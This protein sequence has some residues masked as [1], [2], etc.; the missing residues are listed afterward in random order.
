MSLT[1]S[2][3]RPLTSPLTR[4]L[5]AAGGG[6]AQPSALSA[7]KAGIVADE[8]DIHILW[9]GDSTSNETT[10]LP[11]ISAEWLFEQYP[12]HTVSYRLFNDGGNS[13]DAA[14]VIGT[15]S[16]ANTIHIW[17]ASVSGSE[18]MYLMGDRFDAAIGDLTPDV[19]IWNH[20]HNMTTY[21]NTSG[22]R[23]AFLSGMEPVR[24]AHPGVPHVAIRQN[25][26]RDGDEMAPVVE[27][28]DGVAAS[29]GDLT[30]IDLY[31][32]YIAAGKPA[33]WYADNVHPD[34]EGQAVSLGLFQ[35]AFNRAKA[36]ADGFAVADAF[37]ATT[38]TNLLA[39]AD[40]GSG[41]AGGTPTGWSNSNITATVENTVVA[42]GETQSMQVDSTLTGANLRR[43]VTSPSTY[44]GQT[45]TYAV[46][47]YIPAGEPQTAGR[48]SLL[49]NAGAGDVTITTP[50]RGTIATGGWRWMIFCVDL[51]S[52]LT[53]IRAYLYCDSAANAGGTTVYYDRAVLVVGDVPR[54]IA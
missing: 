8:G 20:G 7:M 13:Y 46:R 32:A 19:I 5:T 10:E 43:A 35:S 4:A 42:P 40:F 23:G 12:T 39:N 51:P 33:E 9:I 44:D 37:L 1:H 53:L 25:P 31:A 18:A 47:Q 36:T 21:A 34:A 28:L 50:S 29:Y 49:Y 52:S 3:T 11:Y 27:A 54:N 41:Y 45:L 48:L 2:L 14:D 16:G 26:W 24:L 15:G 6:R 38:G 22:V 17:N 30:L